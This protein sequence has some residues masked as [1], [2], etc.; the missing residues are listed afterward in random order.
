MRVDLFCYKITSK[1]SLIEYLFQQH[2]KLIHQ[3]FEKH[4]V[5]KANAIGRI[6]K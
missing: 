1:G 6:V 3:G 5:E 4:L 2:G